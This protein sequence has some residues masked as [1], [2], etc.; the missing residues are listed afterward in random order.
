ML[1][2]KNAQDPHV[3]A[4]FRLAPTDEIVTFLYLGRPEGAQPDKP[5]PEP[6]DFVE[7]F[8]ASA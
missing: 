8:G 3:K 1:T 6:A 7:P 5:R 2:G 4:F